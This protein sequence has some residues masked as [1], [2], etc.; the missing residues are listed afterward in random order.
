MRPGRIANTLLLAGLL[1]VG[2]GNAAAQGAGADW[3]PRSGDAWVDAWL[4][5]M[6]LY[7]AR[8][9]ESFIDELVRYHAAPRDL[10]TQLLVERR[11]APGDVYYACTLAQVSGR[12]CRE[13]VDA[14]AA[15]PA[16]GWGAVARGLGIKPGSAEFRR[17]KSGIVPTY[18]RWSRPIELDADLRRTDPGHVPPKAAP[19]GKAG[20][21]EPKGATPTGNGKGKAKGNGKH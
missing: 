7:G 21:K 5:D 18:E 8:Y 20:D 15:N 16:Q 12:P 13:V 4:G 19:P 14:W 1:A 3:N 11:W 6:N 2:T 9:R 10:V 17:L